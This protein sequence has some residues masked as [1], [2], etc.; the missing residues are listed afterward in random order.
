[1]HKAWASINHVK[2]KLSVMRYLTL[3]EDAFIDAGI[4]KLLLNS[5]SHFY[6]FFHQFPYC[7]G[8]A[9]GIIPTFFV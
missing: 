4:Y 5:L 3:L 6:F 2:G 7:S 8:N 1:M 9:I